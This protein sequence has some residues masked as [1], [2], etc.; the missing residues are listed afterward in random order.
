MTLKTQVNKMNDNKPYS[1][2]TLE[3]KKIDLYLR[4]KKTL[5]DFLERNAISKEQFEKSLGDL[6]EKM[7]MEQYRSFSFTGENTAEETVDL[8][9]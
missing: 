6:T 9:R 2:M 3:E 8:S 1:E 7:G 5:E 4:Q